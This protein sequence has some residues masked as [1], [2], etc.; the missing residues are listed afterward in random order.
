M[1]WFLTWPIHLLIGAAIISLIARI[2]WRK[3]EINN[4]RFKL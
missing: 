1:V 2:G 4:Q 3:D